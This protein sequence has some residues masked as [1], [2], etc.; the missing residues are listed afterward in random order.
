MKIKLLVYG[1]LLLVV[2]FVSFCA[3]AVYALLEE[4]YVLCLCFLLA[5][6][7]ALDL[8]SAVNRKLLALLPEQG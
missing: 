3:C 8:R 1:A 2:L 4:D 6:E 7:A 5:S